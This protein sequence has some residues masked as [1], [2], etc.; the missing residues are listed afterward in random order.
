[1]APWLSLCTALPKDPRLV[2]TAKINGSQ[3]P[4][5]LA[6]GRPMLSSGLL[7]YHTHTQ[8]IFKKSIIQIPRPVG[9][10]L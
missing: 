5:A 10:H 1:M 6:P 4:V 8:N 3:K 7:G 9:Q 2:L